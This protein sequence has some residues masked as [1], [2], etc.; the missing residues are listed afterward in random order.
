MK[1]KHILCVDDEAIIL[2]SLRHELRNI[3]GLGEI[4][5][6][7]ADSGPK[8][9]E[10]IEGYRKEGI[11][12][13]LIIS[14]QRM[15][16][17]SGDSFLETAHDKLPESLKILLTGYSDFD[18]VIRLVNKN[19]LYRYLSK[20]WDHEDLALTLREA[21]K[22]WNQ[23]KQIAI[24]QNKIEQLTLAMVTA[25]ESANFYFDEE[26][27]NHIK[28]IAKI[29]EFI[30]RKAGLDD[31]Y[32]RLIKMYAPLHDIGKVGVGKD[33]LLK[34]ARLTSEEFEL[35]K[36]HVKIGYRIINNEAIDQIAKNIV[37]YHH[38]KWS[39]SGYTEG[40]AGE[41]IPLEARI[42]SIADV[43]DALVSERVYK[44][45]YSFDEAIDIIRRERGKSF[46]PKLVDVFLAGVAELENPIDFFNNV[47]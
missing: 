47:N 26:T 34:P 9:L 44:P 46:D 35:V 2:Q 28:R 36:D 1:R 20:P 22:T 17:M 32:I 24:Q 33:I 31:Q 11:E 38:E 5:I 23:K 10:I 43:F 6:D 3:P 16:F 42:V 7:T 27:G 15:P 41:E 18:A 30:A 37:L 40:K 13:P 19:I 4:I 25:L 45:A 21:L 8:A 12:V 14:D 29:S 39:G